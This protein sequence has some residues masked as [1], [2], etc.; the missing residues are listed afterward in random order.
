MIL[1]ARTRSASQP[2]GWPASTSFFAMRSRVSIGVTFFAMFPARE[3]T[4]TITRV[5]KFSD[6]SCSRR[7]ML[8]ADCPEG[9]VTCVSS[10][11]TARR[12]SAIC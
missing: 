11:R 4:G 12:F 6:I 7:S 5:P 9:P 10:I 3:T 2:A 1:N 8:G